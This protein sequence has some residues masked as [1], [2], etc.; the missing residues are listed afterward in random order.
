MLAVMGAVT[1]VAWA[2][3]P[4]IH[5]GER[6][7]VSVPA[8]VEHAGKLRASLS[9]GGRSTPLRI[10][11]S[12]ARYVVV[13]VD[14]AAVRSLALAAHAHQ[15][16][17]VRLTAG[18]RRVVA[19]SVTVSHATVARMAEV[20]GQRGP[21][22]AAADAKGAAKPGPAPTV[23]TSTTSSPPVAPSSGA[24]SAVQGGTSTTSGQASPSTTTSQSLSSAH[25]AGPLLA[26]A[27]PQLTHPQTIAVQTGQ[28][29]DHL[30]LSTTQDYVLKLPASG[31]H[32]TL[33]IDGGHNVVLIGGSITVPS[34]ANQTDN[35]ADNTD[36]AIYVRGSTGTVHIEGVAINADPN[37]M[38]DAVDVNAPQATVDVENVRVQGV[39]GSYTMEH[40]DVIQTWGGAKALRVDHLTAD[41]DYQGLTIAPDLGTVGSAD[42]RNVDL[43]LDPVPSALAGVTVGGGYLIWLTNGSTCNATPTTFTNV[44]IVD[45]SVQPLGKLAW[46]ATNATFGCASTLAGGALSWSG[47]PVQGSVTLSAP[48]SGSFVPTGV[49]GNT[50]HSPGYA[51][52]L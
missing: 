51:T 16:G 36:T 24:T 34:T 44:Y 42:I 26:W 29:P 3:S 43:T 45:K 52:A 18:S 41:G 46:P 39:Y 37:V 1:G 15:R 13:L 33:E 11:A 17:L 8:S 32:G 30:V 19:E 38:F 35:G 50:Y 10:I 6:L 48:P 23:G 7:K 25:P 21:A 5:T 31:I 27:P 2:Q 49:A 40:A 12:H 22:T 9:V 20:G 14:A 4:A 47:I 28:D